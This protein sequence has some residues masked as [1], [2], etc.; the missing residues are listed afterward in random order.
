[1]WEVPSSNPSGW[2]N[3]YVKS[4]N[5]VYQYNNLVLMRRLGG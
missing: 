4:I 3:L 1:M 5:Y 2:D